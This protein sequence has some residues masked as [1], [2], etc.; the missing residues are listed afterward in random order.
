MLRGRFGDT[1]GRPYL[2]GR[3]LIPRLGIDANISFLVD[4]GAD[5][6]LLS[7][8]D[9][10]E[11]G[12]DYSLLT[13]ETESLGT[14]GIAHN[15]TEPASIAFTEP[16]RYIYIYHVGLEIA[17]PSPEI[18]QM[19][20]LLGREIVDRWRMVYNPRRRLLTFDVHSAD[21]VVPIA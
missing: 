11:M 15:F 5:T 12:V 3:L 9:A 21:L 13:G 20:S 8:A 18:I 7:P 17:A 6:S 19:P 14:A 16:G 4:T 2:E 1:T 10:F